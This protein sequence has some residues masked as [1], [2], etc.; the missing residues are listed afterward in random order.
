MA[1]APAHRAAP[2]RRERA[3]VVSMESGNVR[4]PDQDELNDLMRAVARAA[5]RPAFA[6]LFRYFAPRIKGYLVRSG[7]A[8]ALAEELTQETMVAIWRRAASFDPSRARL[9]TWIFTIARNL[10]IDHLRRG[11]RSVPVVEGEG[12][13]ADQQPADQALAPDQQALAAQREVNVRQ[14]LAALPPDQVQVLMLSYF[15]DQPHA[16]IADQLGIPLGTV[17]SRIRL[18]VAQLRRRLEGLEP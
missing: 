6:T 15:E 8:E 18:A 16:R 14:A 12:W 10:R 2:P 9:S 4:M 5:D 1:T 17:K 3:G 13:D 7:C 11:G